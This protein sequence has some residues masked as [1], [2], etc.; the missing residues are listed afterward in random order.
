MR[1]P[2]T[3]RWLLISIRLSVAFNV[4]LDVGLRRFP[5]GGPEADIGSPLRSDR[6]VRERAECPLG[7]A[8]V[9]SATDVGCA[10]IDGSALALRA[11]AG[12][13]D[14]IAV[15][16]STRGKRAKNAPGGCPRTTGIIPSRRVIERRQSR[17]PERRR[18][19]F[20]VPGAGRPGLRPTG[21][22]GGG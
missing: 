6:R 18:W 4:L 5:V 14:S 7:S 21:C 2:G 9:D 16:S 11:V 17:A 8:T 13:A 1:E 22:A 12:D 10:Q 15:G 20:G 19:P 3:V